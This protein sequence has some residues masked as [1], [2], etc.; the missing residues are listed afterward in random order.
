MLTDSTPDPLVE[1]LAEDFVERF[2]K[3]ERPSISEYT[4][5]H[6]E[7]ARQI[8]EIFPAL[9]MMEQVQRDIQ[10]EISP[11]SSAPAQPLLS[12]LGDYR[13]IREIGRGG[14]GVVYEAE[15]VSL[16][17]R[18]ALKVLSG[19]MLG[20]PRHRKRF[21]REAKAAARLHHTNIVPVFGV[22]EQ[23]GVCYYVM[24]YIHGQGL[25]DVLKELK[26]L[27]QDSLAQKPSVAQ[28]QLTAAQCSNAGTVAPA[29]VAASLLSGQFNQ[30]VLFPESGSEGSAPENPANHSPLTQPSPA[31]D[32]T[33]VGHLSDTAPA[34]TAVHLPGQSEQTTRSNSRVAYWHSIA[35]IGVQVAQA[36]Q[37]AHEQGIIHRDIKP[38]NLLLDLRGSVWVTDFG[39]AKASDQQDLTHTGDVL[40]T[41]RY[42]APEQFDGAADPRSDLYSLGLTLYEMLAL[43]PAFDQSERQ[44]L[45]KQVTTGIPP[46]LR[47]LDRDIPRDLETVIHKAIDRDPT[48]R[49]QNA[50]DLADDLSRFL[51]DEPIKAR[52][53]SLFSQFR[54]WCRKNPAIAGLSSTIALL[55]TSAAVAASFAAVKFEKLAE[56]NG[57][58]AGKLQSAL[59]D[60]QANLTL[61]KSEK[62]R[63]EDNLAL[64]TSEQ[65]RAEGNLDLALKAMDAVYL[66][67]IGEQRLLSASRNTS[68][69]ESTTSDALSPLERVLLQKGLKFY[70]QFAMSNPDNG[71][72]ADARS[73]QAVYRVATI[74]GAIE[75]RDAAVANFNEAIRRYRIL[76]ENEPKNEQHTFHLSKALYGLAMLQKDW[77]SA[78]PLYTEAEAAATRAISSNNTKPD[79][80]LHR[81]YVNR[82]LNRLTDSLADHEKAVTLAPESANVLMACAN[83]YINSSTQYNNHRRALELGE[84]ALKY[85]PDN[86]YCHCALGSILYY[87]DSERALHHF[88]EA[89]R[90]NPAYSNAYNGRARV[91]QSRGEYDKAISDATAAV[92]LNPLSPGNYIRRG[93]ALVRLGR[94]KEARD[95]IDMALKYESPSSPHYV[96]ALQ[97]KATLL[98][99]EGDLRG[100]EQ[101]LTTAILQSPLIHWLYGDRMKVRLRMRNYDSALS[102]YRVLKELFPGSGYLGEEELKRYPLSFQQGV[103]DILTELIESPKSDGYAAY[104]HGLVRYR[105]QLALGRTSEATSQATALLSRKWDHLTSEATTK[106]SEA[107]ASRMQLAFALGRTDLARADMTELVKA[108]N[109]THR[110]FYELALLSLADGRNIDSYRPICQRMLGRFANST[111]LDAVSLTGW[112]CAL[113]PGALDDYSAAITAMQ[114]GADAH[115]EHSDLRRSLGALQLRAGLFDQALQTLTP[116]DTANT[117]DLNAKSSNAYPLFFIAM[118]QHHTGQKDTAKATLTR[119][120][121]L[122]HRELSN[123]D[124]L[125]WNRKLT[126]EL[127]RDEAVALIGPVDVPPPLGPNV[128]PAPPAPE[129]LPTN[130]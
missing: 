82:S 119:A 37:H 22:G 28:R 114:R 91:H 75:D 63:A 46:R 39:L 107:R 1:E 21:E 14:M 59:T 17:R 118:A 69:P 42:M 62:Q 113:V 9:V 108:E 11:I 109:A 40:G 93:D 55:V 88:S 52:R 4:Q 8:Q 87:E 79:Y 104:T 121:T 34:Q 43:R 7:L 120:V 54:R 94:S 100:A 127:L 31:L 19:A 38:A 74:Q 20:D 103:V 80:Y 81:G 106:S 68:R 97:S 86:P 102:D 23:D 122:A 66:E 101:A 126:L 71:R 60:S 50:A 125:A 123:H 105:L 116:L 57:Q 44:Q 77:D 124:T 98:K 35:R 41:L 117:D 70:E 89:L 78:T 76:A 10:H 25:D 13:I 65:Q 27:R 26:Q 45:I 110:Q 85:D 90:I 6:P 48:H 95:D 61:A 130:P 33:A 111:E 32:S 16:G 64:A 96:R 12:N 99:E 53:I 56:E 29:S 83:S 2:R 92:R 72:S 24:Q 15:Q 47:T 36:L 18:V 73:A 3:G 58:I 49:Y 84:L 5:R 51:G 112:T 128:P 67:A 129:A 115:P 30:T